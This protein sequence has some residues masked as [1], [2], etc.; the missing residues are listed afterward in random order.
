MPDVKTEEGIELPEELKELQEQAEGIEDEK[1]KTFLKALV[2]KVTNLVRGKKKTDEEDEEDEDE[3]NEDEDEDLRRAIAEAGVDEEY[4]SA[5]PVLEAIAER[6]TQLQK[7]L[8]ATQK[9]LDAL[10]KS[11]GSLTERM[12]QI[13]KGG[14]D[15][16]EMV[17]SVCAYVEGQ[18]QG[19]DGTK[20]AD[21]DAGDGVIRKALPD[22]VA[23]PEQPKRFGMTDEDLVKGLSGFLA[24]NPSGKGD[25]T[26]ERVQQIFDTPR[27]KRKRSW[28]EAAAE[29]LGVEL[30]EA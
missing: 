25:V 13:E 29:G 6:D 24:Q 28:Y 3:E 26:V 7:S 11:V 22:F 21:A 8:K 17:K 1:S 12:G 30:S 14:T 9:S 2:D 27:D 18:R 10:L 20:R 23:A 19:P 16:R 4:M 5:N 15:D